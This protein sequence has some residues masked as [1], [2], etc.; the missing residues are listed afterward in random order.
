MTSSDGAGVFEVPEVREYD[1]VEGIEPIAYWL[2][3]YEFQSN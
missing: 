2:C 1:A 3:E